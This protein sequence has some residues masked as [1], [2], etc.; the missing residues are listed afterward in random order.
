[1]QKYPT[2]NADQKELITTKMI[3]SPLPEGKTS[4]GST[5]YPKSSFQSTDPYNKSSGSKMTNIDKEANTKT[6]KLL[7]PKKLVKK[8]P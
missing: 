8:P 7:P 6:G 4:V 2:G 1:M 3:K 5:K